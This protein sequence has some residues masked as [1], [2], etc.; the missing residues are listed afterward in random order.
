MDL[1]YE[2]PFVRLYQGDSR[3]LPL[4]DGT[5]SCVVTSPPYLG[6]RKYAGEQALMWDEPAD[7]CE[8]VWGEDLYQRQRGA[9][10]GA[11]AQAGN[12][13]RG[14]SGVGVQ[15][16]TFCQ[17]CNAWR[18]DFGLEPTP[19]LYIQHLM[20]FMDELWRVLRPDGVVFLNLGDSMAGN[21]SFS[22]GHNTRSG[23]AI[24]ANRSDGGNRRQSNRRDNHSNELFL[25][26]YRRIPRGIRPKS[27]MLIPERF[28]LACQEAGWI[29]RSRIAWAK[30]NPM[31]ES[32]RDR[33]T[34]SWE[35][36]WMLTKGERYWWDQEAV[37]EAW[38]DTRP[39]DIRRATNGSPTYGGKGQNIMAMRAENVSMPG[40]R[41]VGNPQQGRNLRNVWTIATG[42]YPEAHFAVF[43]SAIAER[44]IL[45]ACPVAICT[46]CG[47]PRER[48]V[49]RT[50][51]T[52]GRELAHVPNNT[53]TKTD[54]TGWA[55]TTRATDNWTN[56]GCGTPWTPGLV[57]D[58][59][60]GSMTTGAVAQALGRR[61]VC[62]D[63][64][65][66]YIQLGIKRLEAMP[67]PLE[68][69]V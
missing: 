5:V 2:T 21:Q 14:V 13:S 59:F 41:P 26:A 40:I 37:R 31:P 10:H 47:K 60:G 65:E 42:P 55:P 48:I 43:P 15:Q 63:L 34:D 7:D 69:G 45:A 6:L 22:E 25:T 18:G 24:A 20:V 54:S 53:P 38:T 35:H 9:L 4:E 23:L 62:V 33:P 16:G 58:P 28:A 39:S 50:G 36:I 3:H 66:E 44:C 61:A 68:M 30:P 51:H 49:E 8:H 67:L 27:L 64:A 11:N 19:R 17:R 57:L 46:S 32:V 52:N 1:A 56:C 29:V 12:T